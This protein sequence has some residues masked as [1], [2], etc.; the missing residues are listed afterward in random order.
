VPGAAAGTHGG[1]GHGER[2]RGAD[3]AD[4]TESDA[5][6]DDNPFLA[7]LSALGQQPPDLAAP[8][9]PAALVDTDPRGAGS[10]GGADQRTDSPDPALA[11][12]VA[13]LLGVFGV[14]TASVHGAV[15]DVVTRALESRGL[16]GRPGGV[17]WGVATVYADPVQARLIRYV[18][19]EV[20]AELADA[21]DG[22]VRELRIKVA[23][24]R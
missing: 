13:G 23:R 3:G 16:T 18:T 19:D 1:G 21:T 15:D 22:A 5:V 17:R 7:A 11:P 12:L 20:V 6:P 14:G 4:D 24:A 2:L 8:D 10:S 9:R